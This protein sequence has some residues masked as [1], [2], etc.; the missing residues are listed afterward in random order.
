MDFKTVHACKLEKNDET[1]QPLASQVRPTST[2]EGK[3][4]VNCAYR[5]CPTEMQLARWHNEVALLKYLSQSVH[6]IQKVYSQSV[7]T[8]PV[9]AEKMF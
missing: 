9:V 4:K 5:L 1:D 8:A 6:T 2:K 3:G 7:S